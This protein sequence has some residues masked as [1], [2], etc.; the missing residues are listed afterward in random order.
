MTRRLTR[1]T[2]AGSFWQLLQINDYPQISSK[3]RRRNGAGFL[4]SFANLSACERAQKSGPM[5][6]VF[7]APD[8]LPV[9]AVGFASRVF[10][11]ASR[12]ARRSDSAPSVFGRFSVMYRSRNV[13]PICWCLSRLLLGR[14]TEAA[15]DFQIFVVDTVILLSRMMYMPSQRSLPAKVPR[16]A[17]PKRVKSGR[18]FA[19]WLMF[20]FKC[21]ESHPARFFPEQSFPVGVYSAMI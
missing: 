6:A 9:L 20:S 5:A 11:A 14:R 10:S 13:V 12:S 21:D 2:R 15:A 8:Q 19:P 4:L 7:F 16:N 18:S 3:N 17:W 1:L